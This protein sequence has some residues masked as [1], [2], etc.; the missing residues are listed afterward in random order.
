MLPT[1]I[2]VQLLQPEEL[3][4]IDGRR[5]VAFARLNRE[6]VVIS[7]QE[8]ETWVQAPAGGVLVIHPLRKPVWCRI[9][10]DGRYV[11]SPVEYN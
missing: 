11:R 4:H 6:L 10:D 1:H 5:G 7:L 8:G 9:D 3:K 2:D